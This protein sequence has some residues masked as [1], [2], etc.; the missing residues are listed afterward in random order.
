[1]ST[2]VRWNPLREMAAMQNMMDRMFNETL[3]SLGPGWGETGVGAFSLALDIHETDG[4]YTVTTDLPG[5]T[6]EHI[7][8]KF[9]D[10]VLLIEAEIPEQ[11]VQKEGQRVLMQERRYGKFSR[12]IRLPQPVNVAKVEASF[13]DG[14]LTLT[15]PKAEEAQPRLIPVK[16]GGSKN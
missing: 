1:M 14:V 15:L 6:A 4:D 10:G 9:Q 2:I 16:A 5:V 3:R 11:T 12:S 8:V 13:Q 7:N